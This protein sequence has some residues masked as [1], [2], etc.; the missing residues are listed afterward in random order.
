MT[1]GLERLSVALPKLSSTR[2][3][4]RGSLRIELRLFS[5]A[6]LLAVKIKIK[7]WGCEGWQGTESSGRKGDAFQEKKIKNKRRK[8]LQGGQGR[9]WKD[10]ITSKEI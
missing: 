4:E 5:T 1:A 7:I 2:N 10:F 9:V 8:R 6:I 3:P